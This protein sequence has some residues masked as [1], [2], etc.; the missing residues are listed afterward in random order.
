VIDE[1][2]SADGSGPD[3]PEKPE[4]PQRRKRGFWRELPVL[5]V[6][7]VGV[8]VIVRSFVLQTFW[9]PSESMQNTLLIN[10]KVLVNKL[11]Y[12]IRSPHRG[13][14]VVFEAPPSWHSGTD[15]DIIKRIIGEPGDHVV[16]CDDR[17][18]ITVNDRPIDEPY[19]Y[20]TGGVTDKP[21]ERP[22]DVVVPKGR[23]WMMGDHRSNSADSREH[24]FR[25]NDVV[26]ATVP[27]DFVIGRAFVIFWPTGHAG[28]LTVPDTFDSVP[29]P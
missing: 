28:W 4:E 25:Q 7:A 15:E 16:C 22:F 21:S 19:L 26:A 14:V 5:L 9:I 29:D 1:P 10:D 17:G 8:A 27:E 20:G 3:E 6:I 18:R 2:Q 24:Y 13:E 23:Y 11:I 12:Y